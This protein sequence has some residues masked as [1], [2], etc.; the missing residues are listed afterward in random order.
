MQAFRL[1][2][3]G[4]H[5]FAEPGAGVLP[6]LLEVQRLSAVWMLEVETGVLVMGV[7]WLV[8]LVNLTRGNQMSRAHLLDEGRHALIEVTWH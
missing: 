3:A 5:A 7:S 6:R 8:H 1:E 2:E 4:C